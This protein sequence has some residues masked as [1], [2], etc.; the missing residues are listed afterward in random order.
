MNNLTLQLNYQREHNLPS[1]ADVPL[2]KEGNHIFILIYKKNNFDVSLHGNQFYISNYRR[3]NHKN[4][5]SSY[6]F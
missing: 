4:L 6:H 1:L 5:A 2:H 3:K